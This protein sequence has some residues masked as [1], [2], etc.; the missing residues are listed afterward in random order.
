MLADAISDEADSLGPGLLVQ[1][2]EAAWRAATGPRP[3]VSDFLPDGPADPDALLALLSTNLALRRQSGEHVRVEEYIDQFPNLSLDAVVALLYED[4][5]LREEAGERPSLDDYGARFPAASA[6]LRQVLEIHSLVRSGRSAMPGP[7]APH[8]ASLPSAGQTIAGFRLAEE[9][10]R[11]AFARVFR[12]EERPLASRPVALKVT[13]SASCEPQALARL[14]HTYIVPIYSYRPDPVT[15]LHLLCMPFLGR[16]TLADLLNHPNAKRIWTGA[17]LLAVL[18]QLNA[19]GDTQAARPALRLSL[20]QRSYPRA[21]AWWGACL[22]EALQHAHERGILHRDIKPS[23][24]LITDD[25]LPMLLDFNL[26]QASMSKDPLSEPSALGGTLAYMAPEHLEALAERSAAEVDG[27]A[28]LFALG[29]V[30]FEALTSGI[31]PFASPRGATMAEAVRRAAEERR[32]MPP[33]VRAVRPEVP[34][35]IEAVVMRCMHPDPDQRYATAADLAADL[36]A[37]AD[38]APLRFAA[39]PLPNRLRRW[40]RR[41]RRPLSFAVPSAIVLLALS[42]TLLFAE[43]QRGRARDEIS[44]EISA[45]DQAFYDGELEKSRQKLESVWALAKRFFGAE[46]LSR[47]D[48]RYQRTLNAI[49]ARKRAE[50]FSRRAD[51][52][53]FVLL[54]F[55]G[56]PDRDFPK[57]VSALQLYSILNDPLWTSREGSPFSL[58]DEARRKRVR[59]DAEDLLFLLIVALDKGEPRTAQIDEEALHICKVARRFVNPAGPWAALRARY[60]SRAVKPPI[61]APNDV[62]S[63]QASFEW[64]LLNILDKN[65]DA[66]IRWLERAVD[67]RPD[68]YWAQFYLGYRCDHLGRVQQ[69]LRAYT[70]ATI[71]RPEDPWAYFNRA[72][73]YHQIESWNDAR[74]DL[75]RIFRLPRGYE[76]PE[77]R[78]ESGTI[79][80]QLG[81]L[82]GARADYEAVALARPESRSARYALLNLARLDVLAGKTARARPVFDSLLNSDPGDLDARRYRALVALSTGQADQS[83]SDL[84]VLIE[85]AVEKGNFRDLAKLH[86]LRA[87]ARLR[88]GRPTDAVADAGAALRLLHS[89]SH[90]RLWLRALVASRRDRDLAGLLAVDDPEQFDL[91]PLPGPSLSRDL[92]GAAERLARLTATPGPNQ[93]AML[94]A[95]AVLLAALGDPMAQALADSALAIA[96]E[97]I[98]SVLVQAQIR[99]RFGNRPG[100]LA[101]VEQGLLRTPGSARLLELRGILRTELGQ[102][103][104]ALIDFETAILR[105][106]PGT[107]RA[108]RARALLARG[109][110]EEAHRAWTQA[111]KFDSDDPRAFLGRAW[112]LVL[113]RR[114]DEALADLENAAESSDGRAALLARTAL[115]YAA[116]LPARPNRTARA[117]TLAENAASSWLYA[118]FGRN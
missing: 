69:A 98:E 43:R 116:C 4:Y 26:A 63:P 66:S 36:H 81:D 112:T 94:R 96:P 101:A 35:E 7:N 6:D 97:S 76:V 54:G 91:L 32:G 21:I 16:V 27:R 53:R 89:P 37:V 84:S 104:P 83:E 111:L 117:V 52:L 33:S 9:L 47:F 118:A 51:Q 65:Y 12:A 80:Q 102:P 19:A 60:D 115:I 85:N 8:S 1:R 67:L 95:R 106:A 105:G 39:E 45:A 88:F 50:D 28:D 82:A 49:G 20:A 86:A 46:T 29:V 10:G 103:L 31:R 48:S 64:A 2:Y 15:G 99:R 25:G 24:V 3:S 71:L 100:A 74:A 23:N 58:L 79:R 5:C 22:A 93:A 61:P 72:K 70:A 113:L 17:D 56:K 107:V 30:L 77:A 18:D 59:E 90:E 109:Q 73:L 38:D 13:R 110:L 57:V 55:G 42:A 108:A 75:D 87:L 44:R 11:G 62:T 34:V 78:L 41:H 68:E 114:W 40:A 14:Q 92:R